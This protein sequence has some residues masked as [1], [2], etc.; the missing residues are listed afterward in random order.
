[1]GLSAAGLCDAYRAHS[2]NILTRNSDVVPFAHECTP[3]QRLSSSPVDLVA[4][5]QAGQS[6]LDMTLQSRMD[7][8]FLRVSLFV[9]TAVL[10]AWKTHEVGRKRDARLANSH[11]NVRLDASVGRMLGF[12]RRGPDE[13]RPLA[14]EHICFR[15]VGWCLRKLRLELIARSLTRFGGFFSSQYASVLDDM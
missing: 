6:M 5:I 15:L 9:A 8:L 7:V 11:E 1:M 10:G 14:F 2:A 4:G 12:G 3:S 13:R